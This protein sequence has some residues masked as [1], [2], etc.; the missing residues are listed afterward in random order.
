MDREQRQPEMLK[1]PHNK[2]SLLKIPWSLLQGDAYCVTNT[3][4]TTAKYVSPPPISLLQNYWAQNEWFSF[5]SSV[6]HCI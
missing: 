1:R 3:I 6:G 5:P 4:V 2:N